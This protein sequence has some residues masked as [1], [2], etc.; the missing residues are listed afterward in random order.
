MN[1]SYNDAIKKYKISDLPELDQKLFLISSFLDENN[2]LK[3]NTTYTIYEKIS[4]KFK[5]DDDFYQIFY[6][7][8]ILY[9][10]DT[11]HKRIITFID[12]DEKKKNFIF[13]SLNLD[14]KLKEYKFHLFDI[15]YNLNDSKDSKDSKDS[16]DSEY[17]TKDLQS[18]FDNN[19]VVE[20][21]KID[22][23]YQSIVKK[24]KE[25]KK[26]YKYIEDFNLNMKYSRGNYKNQE[27][28]LNK[29]MPK[30]YEKLK[31]FLNN[32][33]NSLIYI[34]GV[35]GSSKTINLLFGIYQSTLEL[36]LPLL[37]LDNELMKSPIKNYYYF[38]RQILDLMFDEEKLT[39]F[40]KKGFHKKFKKNGIFIPFLYDYLQNIIKEDVFNEFFGSKILIVI[41]N[42]NNDEYNDKLNQIIKLVLENSDKLKLIICGNANFLRN[43]QLNYLTEKEEIKSIYL[44]CLPFDFQK[45]S[46]FENEILSLPSFYFRY[47]NDQKNEIENI[48]SFIDTCTEKEIECCKNFNIYGLYNSII[49]EEKLLSYEQLNEFFLQ[50]PNDYLIYEKIVDSHNTKYKFKFHNSIFRNAVIESSKNKILIQSFNNL[51]NVNLNNQLDRIEVGIF[52]ER[53]LTLF[54]KCNKFNIDNIKFEKENQLEVK[55]LYYFR[56]SEYEKYNGTINKNKPIIIT[57]SNF[58]GK[59]YDLLFLMPINKKYDAV[60]IQIGLDKDKKT[61]LELKNDIEQNSNEYKKGIKQFIGEVINSIHLVFIFDKE[62]QKEIQEKKKK[63]WGKN[64]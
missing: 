40:Y 18:C 16:L 52:F 29:E 44:E 7:N 51:T 30:F 24:L 15:N 53:I 2:T 61:I 6:L 11:L 1:I 42:Y 36:K 41:D 55:E 43:K 20:I 32:D 59:F 62:T 34:F 45:L 27:I 10:I 31:F 13:S 26:K 38:K 3:K 49:Y 58:K 5:Y 8:D 47:Y 4:F 56:E 48:Q 64:M 60:F 12:N 37:Y 22:V 46:G 33:E 63:W 35:K 25:K 28:I 14:E 19:N 9:Q 57:Q 39:A 54:F 17:S 23:S 50:L 21:K